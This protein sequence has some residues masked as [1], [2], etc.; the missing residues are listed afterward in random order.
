MDLGLRVHVAEKAAGLSAR[1]AL[2]RID[3]DAAHERH[4]EHQSA[5]ANGQPGDVVP[6]AFDRQL[7]AVLTRGIH[8]RD[9]V[10]YAEAPCDQRRTP[11]DHRVPDGARLVESRIAG[12]QEGP[13]DPPLQMVDNGLVAL[14]LLGHRHGASPRL[15]SSRG[16]YSIA[17]RV[18][19]SQ[20]LRGVMKLANT[21]SAADLPIW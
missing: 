2:G 19:Q 14:D 16:P 18:N 11:I 4:V 1:D 15:G 3:P 20:R 21:N 17:E 12:A 6:T 10:R 5:L 8:A 7:H 9:D 13:P